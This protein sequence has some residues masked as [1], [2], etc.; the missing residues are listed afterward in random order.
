[1]KNEKIEEWVND[2]LENHLEF[3]SLYKTEELLKDYSN[4]LIKAIKDYMVEQLENFIDY[5]DD[6]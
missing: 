1:M 6:V 4:Y 3:F 5:E 2:Y